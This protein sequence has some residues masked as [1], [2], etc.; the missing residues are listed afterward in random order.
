MRPYHDP[1]R[2]HLWFLTCSS[3]T[4]PRVNREGNEGPSPA[5]SNTRPCKAPAAMAPRPPAEGRSSPGCPLRRPPRHWRDSATRPAPAVGAPASWVRRPLPTPPRRLQRAPICEARFGGDLNRPRPCPARA[6]QGG[7]ILSRLDGL[8]SSQIGA[9]SRRLGG[10]R[11]R[12]RS[13][14][15]GTASTDAAT[16]ANATVV[17]LVTPDMATR[18][19][20]PLLTADVRRRPDKIRANRRPM[21]D[22]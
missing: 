3:A 20:F 2:R 22:T 15:G 21:P 7:V 12:R 19:L 5:S 10:P 18:T 16:T 13:H 9:D 6:D 1:T 8:R 11:Q 4:S 14:T 17:L